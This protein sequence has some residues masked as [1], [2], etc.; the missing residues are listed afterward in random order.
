MSQVLLSPLG[1]AAGAV[2]G[3]YFALREQQEISIDK[4]IT[5][6]TRHDDVLTATSVLK[7]LFESEGITYEPH[8]VTARELRRG[9]S[10]PFAH[11]LGTYIERE[12]QD[13]NS[14][15]VAVTGGR[16]GM[17]ALAALAA[18]FYGAHALW[19]LWVDEDTESEGIEGAIKG[20]WDHTNPYLNP[21]RHPAE[22]EVVDLP[23]ENLRP[24]YP[25]ISAYIQHE[26]LPDDGIKRQLL[27]GVG[28][29]RLR[30]LFPA[31]LTVRQVDGILKAVQEWG[32][33]WD[34]GQRGQDSAD[35]RQQWKQKRTA[36]RRRV[37]LILADAELVN[38]E[39]LRQIDRLFEER[40]EIS[41]WLRVL[42]LIPD[43][44]LGFRQ[45]LERRWEQAGDAIRNNKESL[46]N[47]VLEMIKEI[48]VAMLNHQLDKMGSTPTS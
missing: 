5:I 1:R 39:S 46:L 47:W 18:Q 12:Y 14:I 23:F 30:S 33:L 31:E 7:A 8:F 45:Q 21:T 32:R 35:E 37:T 4:I 48:S 9:D 13:Q 43:D 28:V 29:E 38:E 22:C 40:Q 2:S 10:V 25:F 42:D 27:T 19:H 34:L 15:H 17:G 6:G 36:L 26:R 24:L 44:P 3:V 20:N 11:R 16:S 41:Q